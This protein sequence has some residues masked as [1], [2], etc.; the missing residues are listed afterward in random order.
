M[1]ADMAVFDKDGQMVL[2]VEA[3]SQ[4]ATSS[5]WA[6]RYR[7]NL[8]A[9]GFSPRVPFFLLATPE[10][11]YLWK[12]PPPTPELIDPDYDID[13][14]ALLEPYYG[15]EPQIPRDAKGVTFELIVAAWLADLQSGAAME[16]LSPDHRRWL[17]E[18]GLLELLRGGRIALEAAVP[19]A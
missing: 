6:A 5:D 16:G 12:D 10:H 11:F 1:R 3:K 15:A 9:A 18:S 2:L 19:G 8:A 14:T 7:C 4:A 17:V 13:A